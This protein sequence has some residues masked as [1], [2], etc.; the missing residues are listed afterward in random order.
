MIVVP[1]EHAQPVADRLVAAVE[2]QR[3]REAET[4][5]KLIGST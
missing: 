5:A 3:L 2:V 1:A 4:A